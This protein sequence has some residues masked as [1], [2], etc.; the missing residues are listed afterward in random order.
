[1][2]QILKK[3][4]DKKKIK[5]E[6][7][8]KK[9][10]FNNLEKLLTTEKRRDFKKLLEDG[11]INK[12]NIIIGE[13]KKQ[14]PSAGII[15]ENYFPEKI[16]ID[17]QKANIDAISILTE[18]NFFNGSIDD[19]S[20][21]KKNSKIPILRKDFIIDDYQILQSKI[22]N[23]DAILLILSILT[24]SQVKKFI[25]IALKYDLDCLVEAHTL[26][27]VRRAVKIG[28][29]IIGINNRNLKNLNIDYNNLK[30]LRKIIPDE[31]T[32]VAESGIKDK[33]QIIEYNEIGIYNF[34]IGESILKSNNFE[35]KINDLKNL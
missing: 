23:A 17:Y 8:K 24:D 7:D 31:F 27:E 20:I 6:Y 35:K 4:I 34:L 14:S 9:C 28:Y 33:N 12:R 13:I 29:P 5:L 18:E 26:E 30:N 2:S 1:M 21:V 19:L 11:K 3:I 22:Y 32:I 25:K 16:A 10:S 15:I